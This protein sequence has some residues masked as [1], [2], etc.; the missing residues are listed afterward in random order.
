MLD[1]HV[2]ECDVT[3]NFGLSDTINFTGSD[4]VFC[5]MLGSADQRKHR[6]T[7]RHEKGRCIVHA[8][9]RRH[10]ALPISDGERCNLIMWTKSPTFRDSDGYLLR[11]F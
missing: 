1:M 11:R 9:K 7:Y 3:F 5:G 4:L 6:H 10:G 8:G 2:D